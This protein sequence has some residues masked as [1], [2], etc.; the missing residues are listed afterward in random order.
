M[1]KN[2][3]IKYIENMKNEILEN[4][5]P[6]KKF[7]DRTKQMMIS[8]MVRYIDFNFEK[9]TTD[10]YN[11]SNN[12]ANL[13]KFAVPLFLQ[14][15]RL[16]NKNLEGTML[17]PSE[18]SRTETISQILSDLKI[19]GLLNIC[20]K[21]VEADL[22]TPMEI[23]DKIMELEFVN[24]YR[25]L[26]RID[27]G[28]TVVYSNSLL[29]T[30]MPY[31]IMMAQPEN[32]N[33]ILNKMNRLV[34]KWNNDFIGYGAD[35]QVDNYFRTNAAIDLIQD[36][37][38]NC[39]EPKDTFG[40]IYYS[41][42]VDAILLLEMLSLKHVQF[43]YIAINKYPGLKKH[44]IL[45]VYNIKTTILDSL[46][47][48]LAIDEKV[49]LEVFDVIALKQ[50]EINMIEDEILS[51]PP[52]IEIAKDCFL[53]SYAGCLYEPISFMLYKLKKKYPKDWD[54]N[55][56][57]REIRF[58]KEI[59]EFFPDEFF[60][61]VDRNIELKKE[62]KLLTDIDACIYEKRQGNILLIQLKWQDS[63]YDSFSSMLSK[64]KNYI[65]KVEQWIITM[66]EWLSNS[67]EKTIANYL[68][69]KSS[70][71]DKKKIHLLVIGRYNANYSFSGEIFSGVK[72]CQWFELQRILYKFNDNM[73]KGNYDFNNIFEEIEK[74]KSIKEQKRKVMSGI[75]YNGKKIIYD[76]LFYNEA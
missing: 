59:Y 51:I 46:K 47:Y 6:I 19:L 41:I 42:F 30:L 66:K 21:Y 72:Y 33:P 2:D 43:V 11:I 54:K 39:F 36:A 15:T 12:T 32:S 74:V 67:D 34:Y 69:L 8:E 57:K 27:R 56:Q 10:T 20:Q 62:G 49:A 26:E 65:N 63:I 58:R 22:L 18:S 70:K 38:W 4:L 9:D 73:K 68:H 52:Y 35:E 37:E 13:M 29:Q 50:S 60:V 23:K 64:R 5:S 55:I 3:A 76:N 31:N 53:R 75:E 45:P 25:D 28:N 61:K 71:I 16:E 24:E 40:N 17:I 1:M 7:S 48:F 44:N 14:F